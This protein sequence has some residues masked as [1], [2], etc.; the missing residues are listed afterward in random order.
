M[1]KNCGFNHERCLCPNCEVADCHEVP[2]DNCSSEE[3]KKHPIIWC[4]GFKGMFSFGD[5]TYRQE[6]SIMD[7]ANGSDFSVRPDGSV[8]H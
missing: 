6:K 7:L 2:C 3:G 1:G 8:V 5:G 4:T